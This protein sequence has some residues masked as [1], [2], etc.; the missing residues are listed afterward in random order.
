MSSLQLNPKNS[1]E[2]KLAPSDKPAQFLDKQELEQLKIN[3]ASAAHFLKIMSNDSRLLIL[4][5]LGDREMS[6]SELNQCLQISQSALSQHL[7][8]LR[9][10]NLV[11][12]RREAQTIYY[13]L[14]GDAAK[15]IIK[16]L[17]DI[18]CPSL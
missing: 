6:V 16:T 8:I 5:Y 13:S 14:S 2:Q 4:C 17:K 7:A 11:K 15:Q 3:S 9:S 18:F 10:E 12:T 1:P